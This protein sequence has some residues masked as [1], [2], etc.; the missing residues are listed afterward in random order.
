MRQTRVV[1]DAGKRLTF[2][3]GDGESEVEEISGVSKSRL[4]GAGQI[5]LCQVC[6]GVDGEYGE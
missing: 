6:A 4:H 3:G 2:V 1:G 5:K